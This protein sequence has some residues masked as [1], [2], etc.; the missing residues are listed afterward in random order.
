MLL[1]LLLILSGHAKRVKF[2]N[3]ILR[4]ISAELYTTLEDLFIKQITDS[5]LFICYFHCVY[6]LS[7]SRVYKNKLVFV[8]ARE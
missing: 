3:W 5:H 2:S 4:G 8:D 6:E 7:L 1:V